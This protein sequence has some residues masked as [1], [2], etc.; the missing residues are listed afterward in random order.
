MAYLLLLYFHWFTD[1]IK[2]KE[3]GKSHELVFEFKLQDQ[4]NIFIISA[5]LFS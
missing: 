1:Y 3:K 2:L 4:K 5:Q